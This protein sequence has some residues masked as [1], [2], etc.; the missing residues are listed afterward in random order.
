VYHE[1]FMLYVGFHWISLWWFS[2][3][4]R[5]S[6]FSDFSNHSSRKKTMTKIKTTVQ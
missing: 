6:A 2:E 4:E 3:Q 5:T 1:A